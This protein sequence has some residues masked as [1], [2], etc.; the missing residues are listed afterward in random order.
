MMS[1]FLVFSAIFYL[2]RGVQA[3]SSASV[4]AFEN[5]LVNFGKSYEDPAVYGARLRIFHT[6]LLAINEI[7][8]NAQLSWTA[9]VNEHS[10]LSWT[11]FEAKLLMASQD[12]SATTSSGLRGGTYV[13]GDLAKKQKRPSSAA[14]APWLDWRDFG[15]VSP[16]KDQGNCGSCWTFSTT[17]SLEAHTALKALRR[18]LKDGG[19][20][21]RNATF[22]D[23]AQILSEQQLLDCA[24]AFDNNGCDGGLPSHAF[25]YI[26]SSGGLDTERAYPYQD[27]G[28]DKHPQHACRFK[29]SSNEGYVGGIVP[30]GSVNITAFDETELLQAVATMGPV[31][32]AYDVTDDFRFYK[33][34][35]YISTKCKSGKQEVNHA[36]VAVGYGTEGGQ[37]YWTVR[38]SWGTSFGMD[39]Y[40]RIARG[41]NMCGL[42]D[43]ASYP[44]VYGEE[45]DDEDPQVK[46]L[47]TMEVYE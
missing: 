45:E 31:S 30:G 46:Y 38:N 18:K 42:A 34:G 33:S 13:D 40:F 15:I 32:I 25:E 36:V 41:L 16:V 3:E 10:D 14:F 37:D 1:V 47:P 39:G 29:N 6:N 20:V 12:C 8:T 44:D 7:N 21:P 11:E 19:T 5:F 35:V 9:G 43:C 17:G 2:F 24:R 23:Y 4:E 27:G 28:K 26:K 22:S